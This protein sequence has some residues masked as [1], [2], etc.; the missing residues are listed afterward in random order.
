MNIQRASGFTLIELLLSV[1]IMS[2]IV[3]L[4]LPLHESFVRRNDLDL[5]AQNLATTMRRAGTYARAV[6]H[7]NAWSVEIQSS[8]ITLFRG[9]NFAGRN[10][11]FDETTSIPSSI[12]PS[13]L[14]E[15]QFA[16]L[17][18]APNVTGSV[19]L[20]STTNDIRTVT[21]NAKGV[22]SY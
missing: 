19:T 13:G 3:G 5:A 8:T 4:S 9:T 21:V 14:G 16:K 1:A 10:T 7:D 18:A 20:T 15:V 17:S 22:V 11:A 2:L 6:N 12:T